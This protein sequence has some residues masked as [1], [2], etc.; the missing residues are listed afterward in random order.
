[1]KS[2]QGVVLVI[3]LVFLL[4]VTLLGIAAV[5]SSVSQTKMAS[6]VQA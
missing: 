4:C 5:S 1:M 2:Q 6:S 3:A